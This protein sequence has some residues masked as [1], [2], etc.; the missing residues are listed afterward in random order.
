ML[1]FRCAV[2]S[3]NGE[4]DEPLLSLEN[5]NGG[6]LSLGKMSKCTFAPCAIS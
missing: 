5:I 1:C 2:L 6:H 4:P 3:E